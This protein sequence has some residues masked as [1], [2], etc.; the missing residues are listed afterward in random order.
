MDNVGIDPATRLPI[1]SEKPVEH[2][3]FDCGLF[4]IFKTVGVIG[5]SLASGE[6]QGYHED[7]TTFYRDMYEFSW[8]QQLAKMT[9]VDVFNFSK[10][11]QYAKAWMLG[12]TE[13]T[14]DA[15]GHHNGASVNLRQ[16]YFIGLA[17]NDKPMVENNTY[18]AGIGTV[19]DINDADYTQNADSYV[20]WYARIIQ[21]L[22]SV[23]PRAYIFCIT[24]PTTTYDSY[25]E[26][27]RNIVEHFAGQ[28]VYLIDLRQ[29][30]MAHAAQWREMGNHLSAAGYLYAAYEIANYVDWII[31][32]NGA[33]F[34]YTSLVGTEI[35]DTV[36][37]A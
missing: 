27:I 29:Y 10:G 15:S 33:D 34:K 20:G 22:K 17:H 31:R 28:R 25:S 13:R 9:G 21:A 32:N 35:Y 30:G 11:G 5:D 18:S 26:Q 36:P 14:W 4:A 19:A 7:G 12:E 37:T 8:G 1:L 23:E 3:R 2:I 24:P 16:C 6:M